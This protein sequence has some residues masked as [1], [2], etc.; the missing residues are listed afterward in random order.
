MRCLVGSPWC[1]CASEPAGPSK[2]LLIRT[3]Q[4][5]TAASFVF[6]SLPV[7]GVIV[8]LL[9]NPD[10]SCSF[11][12]LQAGTAI[13]DLNFVL[14]GAL[15][16]GETRSLALDAHGKSLSAALLA[17]DLPARGRD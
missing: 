13:G 2:C 10:Q 12:F 15:G 6:K 5:L 16:G 7:P 11:A 9:P 1:S 3:R 8:G 17:L 14:T 4:A